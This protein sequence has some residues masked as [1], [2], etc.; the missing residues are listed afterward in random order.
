MSKPI[1]ER[2]ELTSK[3]NAAKN[4]SDNL[5]KGTFKPDITG[6]IRKYDQTLV[7]YAGLEKEEEKLGAI[8]KDF[9]T[10]MTG[11]SEAIDKLV[12]QRDK[13]K[14]EDDKKFEE[15]SRKFDGFKDNKEVDPVEVIALLSDWVVT[16]TDYISMTKSLDDQINKKETELLALMKK[17][18]TD[19]K[20]KFTALEA[21]YDKVQKESDSAEAQIRA[22]AL[23]YEKS[24]V[25][26]NDTDSVSAVRAFLGQI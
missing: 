17:A 12:Q 14:E 3:W 23:I 2:T 1:E 19:Y 25:K 26:M 13:V 21:A 5:K 16:G 15:Y 11:A 18:H 20:A 8:L 6:L 22:T 24:A 7:V 9:D 4:S 10:K